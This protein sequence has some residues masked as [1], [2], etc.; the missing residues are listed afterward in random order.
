MTEIRELYARQGASSNF[1]AKQCMWLGV[2][3]PEPNNPYVD[4]NKTVNEYFYPRVKI[5]DNIN[6][7]DIIH[8]MQCDDTHLNEETRRIVEVM[9]TVHEYVSNLRPET[10]FG[11][12]NAEVQANRMKVN[13]DHIIK[14]ID[15]MWKDEWTMAYCSF[16]DWAGWGKL[17]GN[18]VKVEPSILDNIEDIKNY[19]LKCKDYYYSV[20]KKYD[21]NNIKISHSPVIHELPGFKPPN[22]FISGTM[23]CDINM[24]VFIAVLLEIKRG[25]TGLKFKEFCETIQNDWQLDPTKGELREE[26]EFSDVII[27][28]RKVF[29]END[30]D[31]LR[32]LYTFFGTEN[33]FEMNKKDI[34]KEFKDYNDSNIALFK[35]HAPKLYDKLS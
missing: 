16:W 34:I 13:R 29:F 7:R 12:I 20:C 18:M 1:I 3:N 6:N 2:D 33:H 22:N 10:N 30:E 25:D 5:G 31:E 17:S 27:D 15:I 11:A 4:I 21:W 28:Y 26:V 14:K 35:A 24:G 32:K 19:F 8:K 23:F 9:K